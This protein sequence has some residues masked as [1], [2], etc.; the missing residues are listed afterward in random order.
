MPGE[1]LEQLIDPQ[2]RA[3][4]ARVFRALHHVMLA[5][6]IGIMLVDTVR[7]WRQSAAGALDAGFW[8]VC[9]FFFAEYVLR[10]IAAP[11]ALSAEHLGKWRTRLTWAI[12]IGAVV[13]LLGVVP[14]ILAVVLGPDF[15]S[16]FG[17][18]WTLKLI[19]YAPGLAGLQRVVRDSRHALL[20]VLIGFC[21]VLVVS[22]SLAYLL[23]R[24]AQPQSFGSMPAALWWAITTVT[25]TGY[26]DVTPVTPLGRMLGGIVMV[27]GILVFAL[28]AGILATGFAE[29]TRRRQ[30]LQTWDLVAKVPFFHDVGAAAIADV[31][32]LLRP[33]EYAARA[34]IVR[35]GEPGDCMYFV[36][37]GDV[38]VQLRPEPVFLGPGEFFGEVALLT[39]GP[40]NATIVALRQCTLLS[41]DI[42]DFRQLLG[43]QPELARVI[44]E[45]AQRRPGGAARGS[46]RRTRRRPAPIP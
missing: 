38:E 11:G 19:R 13:D 6:G 30:F 26:G 20:S 25:T 42:A 32:R 14:G 43:R 40:R 4:G 15:A 23:E 28:W 7:P 36:V 1:R 5:A 17:F 27:S 18:V 22:A 24:A 12:S 37:S 35:R 21:I 41:L 16:L 45:E 9:T 31:A 34:I 2:S 46:G 33:R 44:H 10:L 8:I 3:T 29:E 39:G